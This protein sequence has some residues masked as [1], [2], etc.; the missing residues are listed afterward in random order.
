VRRRSDA[1]GRA[2]APALRRRDD[3]RTIDASWIRFAVRALAD[4]SVSLE[5]LAPRECWDMLA[6][7]GVLLR[8]ALPRLPDDVVAYRARPCAQQMIAAGGALERLRRDGNAP[9]VERFAREDGLRRGRPRRARVPPELR[10][11]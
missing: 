8:R 2:H 7:F 11:R 9:D 5:R 3:A 6:R 10:R 4:P 1:D